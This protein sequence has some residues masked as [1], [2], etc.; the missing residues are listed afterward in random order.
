[1]ATL[2]AVYLLHNSVVKE[3]GRSSIIS[4]CSIR[5]LWKGLASVHLHH[6]SLPPSAQAVAVSGYSSVYDCSIG[7]VVVHRSRSTATFVG[8]AALLPESLDDK[9]CSL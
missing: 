4:R 1:M 3:R 8:L 9:V 7:V 2:A 6:V 5:Y